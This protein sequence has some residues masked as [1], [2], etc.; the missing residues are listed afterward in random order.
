MTTLTL[1]LQLDESL[2][3]AYRQAKPIEKA[4]IKHQIQ[5]LF[6]L[7]WR[8]QTVHDLHQLKVEEMIQLMDEIGKEAEANGLTEDILDEI[9]AES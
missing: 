4:A 5:R 7:Q 9:L 2:V 1:K 8:K 3:L 6:D